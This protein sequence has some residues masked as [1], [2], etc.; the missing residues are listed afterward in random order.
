VID[1]TID[2]PPTRRSLR[3]TGTIAVVPPAPEA[4]EAPGT[5]AA[6]P[7]ALTWL[8]PALVARPAIAGG[9]AAAPYLPVV[10]D[11]L[12]RAPRRSPWR[13]GVLVPFGIVIVLIAA[14]C[15]TTLSWPLH[16][17][18]PRATAVAVQPLTAAAATPAWPAAGSAAIAVQGIGG[19]LASSGDAVSIASITKVVTAL[20]VLEQLPLAPGQPGPE[21]RMTTAD[22]TEYR[23]FRNRGESALDVPVGGALTEY[24]LLQGMLIG[25][26]NNYAQMLADS[27]WPNDQVFANAANGWLAAHGVTGITIVDPTGI[28]AGNRADP[29]ALIPLAERAL[30]HPVIAEIVRTAA[31]ELPGAGHV[32]NTNG[33][34]ADPG[35]VG[36]KTGT[37]R[38]SNNLLAAKDVTVGGTTV[39]LF[40]TTLGQPDDETRQAATRALF[41]QT[42]AELQT[43]PA[44]TVGTVAGQVTTRWGETVGI[45]TGADAT[46]VLW[47]GAT[48][49][50]TTD[51][52]LGDARTTGDDVGTLSLR[53]PLDAATVP[54]LLSGTIDGPTPWWRLTHPLDLFGLSG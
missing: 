24:Q 36:V 10:P 51:F 27:I 47:N 53:G 52:S 6:E 42:E 34:L 41:A 44:V 54:V 14:Y 37:L 21:Y 32:D 17:I 49:T 5:P 46:V 28:E 13:A 11:L 4:P 15:V 40:A 2:L 38:E 50:V 39:R 16:A 20:V 18:P 22:R 3:E 12:A 45:V 30:A 9:I 31:V 29:A 19:P 8:D 1:M 25:S 43:P 33:L 48:P 23:D 35:V 26:A 7:T